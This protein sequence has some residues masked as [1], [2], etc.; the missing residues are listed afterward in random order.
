[1]KLNGFLSRKFGLV[2]FAV[3]LLLGFGF[4]VARS[5]PLAP[6]KVTITRVET[7]SLSSSLFGIGTVEARR[8]YFIGP[9]AAGRVKAVHVDVGEQVKAGQ[10]LA[11]IDPVDL[12]ERLRSLEASYA[13][14]SSAVLAA[15][16][17]RKDVLA[18]QMIASLNAKRY[19][20]LGDKHFVSPSAVESKQ[21]E[22]TSA[23]AAVDASDANL[24]SARQEV[25]RLKADQDALR[26]QRN[27]L[28][29]VAPV[30]GVLTSRDAEAG[31]TVVAGQSVLK[32]IEP[33]SLW[34]KV[35]LDQGRSRGLAA[36]QAASIALRSNPGMPL[37]GK[38][39]RI[40]PVSDSVTEERITL[41]TFDQIPPGL[42]IGEMAEVT[43]QTAANQSGLTLPNAAIKQMPEGSGVW[44]LRDG[45]PVFVAIKLGTSTLDGAVQ[46]LEGLGA[47]DEIIVFS[48][49]ELSEGSRVKVVEQLAGQRQ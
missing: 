47:G 18:R 11:E 26:Q 15:D 19:R 16:A 7:G 17:Q 1:M 2:A 39:V 12:D 20:D 43:V 4:V 30:D 44:K 21:Q 33:S 46:V 28:R 22:L 41:I 10:L 27:N 9:T 40:E 13:R 23:Q 35:R 45:K 42:S 49:R 24:Q 36:G 8:S 29:L 32:L 5:G 6:T 48:E 38:V 14:A 31:S 37:T 34:V 25:I 3:L